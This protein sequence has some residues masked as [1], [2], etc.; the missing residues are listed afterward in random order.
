VFSVKLCA[1]FNGVQ[2]RCARANRDRGCS[3]ICELELE[4]FARIVQVAFG[5]VRG[6]ISLWIVSAYAEIAA[7][8]VGAFRIGAI[9]Q[10]EEQR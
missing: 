6:G 4:F 5:A 8:L 10:E 7:V 1:Q 2:S 3:G 9:T